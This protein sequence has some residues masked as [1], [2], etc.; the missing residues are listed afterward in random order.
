MEKAP[1]GG[2]G[3]PPDL[4]KYASKGKTEKSGISGK[5]ISDKFSKELSL[6]TAGP[7]SAEK[8]P[9]QRSSRPDT[10]E[11]NSESNLKLKR[12]E[13]PKI[14]NSALERT[15]SGDDTSP[16][17]TDKVTSKDETRDDVNHSMKVK[18]ADG[19]ESTDEDGP[20][21][22]SA[23]RKI[24]KQLKSQG[25]DPQLASPLLGVLA[26]KYSAAKIESVPE[27]VFTSPFVTGALGGDLTKYLSTPQSLE[28]LAE[29][30]DLSEDILKRVM[31]MGID[32]M[33]SI[34]PK[35]LFNAFG[36]DTQKITSE[37]INIRDRGPMEGLTSIISNL[38]KNSEAISQ[39]APEI[40][41]VSGT[42]VRRTKEDILRL[43]S[44]DPLAKIKAPASQKHNAESLVNREDSNSR[45]LVAL[46]M[47][48]SL[49]PANPGLTTNYSFPSRPVVSEEENAKGL[50]KISSSSEFKRDPLVES[51]L[52]KGNR[53]SLDPFDAM[54]SQ[55]T[56]E[57]SLKLD[58][59][60]RL[61]SLPQASV[62]Q[63][64]LI[65]DLGNEVH[66]LR[67]EESN[68]EL[69]FSQ[70]K[71]AEHSGK[72][73]AASKD[74]V[75][76]ELD[77]GLALDLKPMSSNKEEGSS[78]SSSEKE[79]EPNQDRFSEGVS[80]HNFA[81]KEHKVSGFDK[82]LENFG[83]NGIERAANVRELM[84]KAQLMIHKNGGSMRIDM[85]GENPVSIA[86]RVN[87]GDVSLKISTQSDAMRDLI[88]SE[89]PRLQESL[90]GSNLKLTEVD[91]GRQL[92]SGSHE[93]QKHDQ[94]ASQFDLFQGQN[95]QGKPDQRFAREKEQ[96]KDLSELGL[97]STRQI[98]RNDLGKL[99]V[100]V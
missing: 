1:V 39:G 3:I 23:L 83:H 5:D 75:N 59:Q 92:A 33:V 95:R 14:K 42:P 44:M 70:M 78:S 17:E 96:I 58:L 21:V 19:N 55:M 100:R 24:A 48:E 9:A 72:E 94:N 30:V 28:E 8:K 99:L 37:L 91:L 35:E 63:L 54:S 90:S 88:S 2:H 4:A 93:R 81:A 7:V 51:L 43:P 66:R 49:A 71:N 40:P 57:K 77:S 53:T 52:I 86:I 45:D 89:I 84:D 12:K 15:D 50:L 13:P 20:S 29:N 65:R 79:K 10:A 41:V 36:L 56:D 16:A 98:M 73:N 82:L 68:S 76:F 26:G 31:E 22:K 97:A 27:L 62:I 32:P 64:S 74:L 61:D 6:D 85:G 47:A 18:K 25:L 87:E 60:T 38:K 11:L 80:S 46:A 69:I 67:L 34:S